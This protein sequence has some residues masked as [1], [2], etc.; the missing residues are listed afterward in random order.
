MVVLYSM[1]KKYFFSK[2]K[3]EMHYSKRD[4]MKMMPLFQYN[5]YYVVILRSFLRH[6]QF[7]GHMV[8]VRSLKIAIEIGECR[9]PQFFSFLFFDLCHGPYLLF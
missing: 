5:I 3:V 4:K 9:Y 6:S 1:M 2:I 7:R 8:T